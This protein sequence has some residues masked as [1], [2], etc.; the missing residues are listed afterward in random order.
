MRSLPALVEGFGA[1]TVAVIGDA[2]L[3]SWLSGEA[4]RL[5]RE[6]PVPVVEV[7]R[8]TVAPGGAGNAAANVAGLGG[9]VR[10]ISAAGDDPDG[11][12]L[13]QAL[14]DRGV[15][16]GALVTTPERR[17]PAKRRLLAGGQLL[18]RFD[19]DGGN[20][21]DEVRRQLADRLAGELPHCDAVLVCDYGLGLLDGGPVRDVLAGAVGHALVV[22]DSHDPTRWSWLEP[23]AITPNH[24]ELGRLLD[25][26][27]DGGDRVARVLELAGTILERSRAALV[28]ATLDRDGAVLLERGRPAHRAY[29]RPEP[30][31]Q[32]SGA[33]DSFAAAFTLALAT[34]ADGPAAV[35]AATAAAA[36]VCALPGTTVCTA[37]DLTRRLGGGDRVVLDT[38]DLAAR[39]DAHRA[40][41]RRVVFTNG[42]FDVLHRGHV[43]YLDQAKRLGDVLVVALNSDAGV[44]RLKGPDRPVN[45]VDDRAAVLAAL[46]CV[47][48][49]TVFDEDTPV[50]LLESVRPDVY[51]K[52]GDY[53][54]DTLPEAPVVRRLGGEVHIVDYLEDRSTTRLL[55]RIRA[56]PD[57]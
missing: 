50:K 51:V 9:R 15:D 52:G 36:V 20:W 12:Q 5:C 40:A 49:L 14:V 7:D 8:R 29:A 27:L 41:G 13:R 21:P 43:S 2:V 4:H 26:P 28:A 38:A 22:V 34:G 53:T 37:A 23:D 6:A 10:F 56:E 48:Y 25:H 35:E 57:R 11:R 31:A 3:D 1:A 39:L 42:C 46:S 16:P 44:A 45:P 30:V 24:D 54:P 18:A 47:D 19:E 33:G 32:T 17:T 55:D